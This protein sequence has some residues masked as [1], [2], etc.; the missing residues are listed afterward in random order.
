MGNSI[1]VTEV[2]VVKKSYKGKTGFWTKWGGR[3]MSIVESQ[4]AVLPDFWYCQ[5]CNDM[6]PKELPCYHYEFPEGEYIRICS[7]CYATGCQPL[8][9]RISTI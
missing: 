9:K 2:V 4:N 8:L 6:Q 5:S 1:T 3:K 7:V